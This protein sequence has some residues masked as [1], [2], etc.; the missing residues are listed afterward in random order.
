MYIGIAIY[1]F[2]WYYIRY[3]IVIFEQFQV[4]KRGKKMS[5]LS[6]LKVENTPEV[7]RKMNIFIQSI[8][9]EIEKIKN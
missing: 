8:K 6:D 7:F 4:W 2:I 9:T 3:K 1:I 5:D